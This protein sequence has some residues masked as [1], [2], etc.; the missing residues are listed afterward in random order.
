MKRIFAIIGFSF[1]LTLIVLN[2]IG[3]K[4]ALAGICL[5]GAGFLFIILFKKAGKFIPVLICLASIAGASLVFCVNYYFTYLP[6]IELSGKTLEAEVYIVDLEE[7]TSE[8]SYS[9][10]VKTSS[11]GSPSS[12]QNIKLTIYCEEPLEYDYYESFEAV[13]SFYS[14]AENGFESFGSYDDG[15]FLKGTLRSA[16]AVRGEIFSVNKYVLLFREHLREIFNSKIGGDNGAL[17]LAVLTGDKCYLS[18]RAYYNFKSCGITHLTAVSG[19]HLSILTAFLVFLLKKLR[20]PNIPVSF[21]TVLV[22][23]FYI[24]LSGFSKSMIRAGIMMLVLII[25][26]LIKKKSDGLNSLGFAAFLVC[27]NPFAVTDAGA[28]LTFTAVIGLCIIRPRIARILYFKNKY[29]RYFI[30]IFLSTICVYI[31]TFPVMYLMFGAVSTVVFIINLIAIPLTQVLLV[32]GILFVF[33]NGVGFISNV[34]VFVIRCVTQIMLNCADFFADFRYSCVNIDSPVYALA[35]A[36][37]FIIFAVGF[38]NKK[39]NTLKICAIASALVF[40]ISVLTANLIDNNNT[41]VRTVSGRYSTCVIVYNSEYCAVFGCREY[42]QYYTAQA[43]ISSNSL[44]LVLVAV[45]NTSIYS[46]RLAQNFEA[47]NYSGVHSI[48]FPDENINISTSPYFNVD[49]WQGFNV[50]YIYN[51]DM[52]I[53]NLTV[54]GTRLSFNSNDLKSSY[55]QDFIYK[56]DENGY[57]L[58][59]VS[60]WLS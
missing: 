17:A 5:A 8:E 53:Y 13:I 4:S 51:G 43:I 15:I 22:I 23:L 60:K 18:T 3:I 39:E 2:L 44:S 21:V 42:N 20:V 59:G 6:Q 28:L 33:L 1:A 19:L 36:G 30:D 40:A 47:L 41:F 29:I 52:Q 27:L 46:A 31:T 34:L 38:L 24:A 56:I 48:E 11:I 55:Q 50:E 9:Y 37:V 25:G 49:L 58:Q 10:V 16:G 7:N 35:I 32:A 45:Q 26:G 54:D 12:P 57:Y 14:F